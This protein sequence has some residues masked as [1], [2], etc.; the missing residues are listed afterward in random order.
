M[1]DMLIAIV[2][3]L[4]WFA[5]IFSAGFSFGTVWTWFFKR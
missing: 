2:G 5:A 1:R 3:N 4:A